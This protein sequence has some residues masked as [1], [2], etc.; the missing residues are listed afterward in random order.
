[1][2]NNEFASRFEAEARK[3]P[4]FYEGSYSRKENK[5][6]D[7]LWLCKSA[8]IRIW[9]A[10][11]LTRVEIAREYAAKFGIVESIHPIPFTEAAWVKLIID[12]GIAETLLANVRAVF[13]Q[14]YADEPVQSFGCCHLYAECSDALK[15]IRP[16]SDNAR[17]CIY[18]GNLH[19][20]RVFYGINRNVR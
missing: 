6:Y 7:T 8:V 12:P 18:R 1:M 10:N 17:G 16:D 14:C 5:S 3:C 2:N 20:G 13:E 15:C 4:S 19:A 9:R 11:T